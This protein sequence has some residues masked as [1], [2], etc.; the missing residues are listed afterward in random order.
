MSEEEALSYV[1]QAARIPGIRG[2]SVTGG[3]PFVEYELLHSVISTAR[4]NG[5]RSRVVTNGYWAATPQRALKKLKRLVDAGLT[6]I[7]LSSDA[8]HETYGGAD[9][10]SRDR[11]GPADSSSFPV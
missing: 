8:L 1:E 3:E 2:I 11:I 6:E 7:S 9:S 10:P 4:Q 5:L